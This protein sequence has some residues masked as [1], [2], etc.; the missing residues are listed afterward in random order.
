MATPS[1]DPS[2]RALAEVT[3]HA[4]APTLLVH[5]ESGTGKE[6]AARRFHTTGP[7][8]AGPLVAVN[9]ATIPHGIAER[10]LFGARKGTYSGAATDSLGCVR[11]ADRGTLFLD[12]IAELEP[13]VQAKLL[14]ALE[15]RVIV[16]LAASHQDLR[17]AVAARTFRED[18]YFRLAHPAVR[19]PPLR[20]RRADIP[21]LVARMLAANLQP[22]AR[23]VEACCL[24]TWPG[25]VRELR[26]AIG[27]AAARA[28]AAGR[29]LVRAEDL[30]EH[31]GRVVEASPIVAK[32]SPRSITRDAVIAA[33]AGATG[34]I[35]AAARALG[36]HRTQLRRLID[37]HRIAV[38][39]DP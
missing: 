2:S 5:G 33:L 21:R 8:A 17:A 36:L 37:H 22:H 24:R 7:R 12:E 20:E 19:I 13:A 28:V 23:L 4:G 25:N 14:R 16:P 35:S 30:P 32:A 27:Q 18:L 10:V 6:L 11:E 9:C 34:N 29:S 15:T 39:R 1:S 38:P 26:N 3:Q 31:A